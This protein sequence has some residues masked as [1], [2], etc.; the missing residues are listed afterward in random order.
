MLLDLLQEFTASLFHLVEDLLVVL[1]IDG[2]TLLDL[3]LLAVGV[4]QPLGLRGREPRH[5][6]DGITSLFQRFHGASGG[7]DH[8]S[9]LRRNA[10][11]P[12]GHRGILAQGA[13]ELLQAGLKGALHIL[14]AL[15]VG[16]MFL[17]QL[18]QLLRALG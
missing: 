9:G 15:Q 12:G 4:C 10:L 5:P 13:F 1:Q 14:H 11:E 18:R 7:S 17:N 2:Q 6:L 3:F 16:L 8:G